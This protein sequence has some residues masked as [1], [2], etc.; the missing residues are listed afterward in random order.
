MKRLIDI[1]IFLSER[2]LAFR[3]SIEEIGS[4][5]NG[6]FLGTFELLAKY[7]NI[8]PELLHRVQTKKT[9]DHY[10][11][12]EIQNEIIQLLAAE[13][14]SINL[15]LLKNAKYYSIILDC[16]PMCLMRNKCQLCYDSSN[17]I[18]KWAY[19]FKKCFLAF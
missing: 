10:L 18:P 2:N 9:A 4:S 8:L 15:G 1:V 6:N 14:L 12:P 16:L 11:S 3:G 17:V 19:I 5:S 13:I 7:D